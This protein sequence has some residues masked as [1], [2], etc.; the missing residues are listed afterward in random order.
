MPEKSQA[1][2]GGSKT[3]FP[4]E[5]KEPKGAVSEKP[6]KQTSSAHQ[7]SNAKGSE[8]TAPEESE[9]KGAENARAM[10]QKFA[11]T[12]LKEEPNGAE[13]VQSSG[14]KSAPEAQSG[15]IG[16]ERP[17]KRRRVATKQEKAVAPAE[18]NEKPPLASQGLQKAMF[19]FLE[20]VKVRLREENEGLSKREIHKLALA[21]PGTQLSLFC[22]SM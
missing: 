2:K 3:T 16:A 13:E 9:P 20:E 8:G 11:K 14:S 12:P 4:E 17:E 10:V 21:E 18:H 15:D 5:S 22:L 1:E 19:K 6:K 7:Q